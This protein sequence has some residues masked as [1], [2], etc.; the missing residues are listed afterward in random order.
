MEGVYD[1]GKLCV[2]VVDVDDEE[3]QL[4][5]FDDP[6]LPSSLAITGV[7]NDKTNITNAITDT[8]LRRSISVTECRV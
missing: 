5:P 7:E 8:T 6:N 2:G 3:W 4:H 1:E